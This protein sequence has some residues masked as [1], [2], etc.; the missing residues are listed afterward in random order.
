VPGEVPGDFHYLSV[1]Q[2]NLDH[3]WIRDLEILNG[4]NLVIAKDCISWNDPM[5]AIGKRD[6]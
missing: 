4:R 5:S 3:K 6:F 2:D 1:L